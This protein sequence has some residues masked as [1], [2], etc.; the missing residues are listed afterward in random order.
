MFCAKPFLCSPAPR[1]LL[2]QQEGPSHPERAQRAP[3]PP[4]RPGWKTS[5]RNFINLL[6]AAP[7]PTKH[8]TFFPRRHFKSSAHRNKR[9]IHH[10]HHTCPGCPHRALSP[11]HFA[12]FLH[13]CRDS[14][15]S[16]TEKLHI[17]S[18]FC[19]HFCRISR[20]CLCNPG[21]TLGKQIE[22]GRQGKNSR[23]KGWITPKLFSEQDKAIPGTVPLRQSSASPEWKLMPFKS[24]V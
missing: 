14:H 11:P 20:S 9:W 5:S 2:T 13:F 7:T 21:F 10:T 3:S 22:G 24:R 12:P 23:G 16:M 6:L 15:C 8:L 1:Y 19:P 4:R 17:F 18:I